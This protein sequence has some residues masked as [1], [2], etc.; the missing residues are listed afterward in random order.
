[1]RGNQETAEL[2]PTT[3]TT[4]GKK[5]HLPVVTPNPPAIPN[6]MALPSGI[7]ANILQAIFV[8][9]F[10]LSVSSCIAMLD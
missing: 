5:K 3:T 1:V 4:E 10:F 7:A 9:Y 8:L 2:L 6:M